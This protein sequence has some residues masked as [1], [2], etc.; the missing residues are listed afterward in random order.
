MQMS[1]LITKLKGLKLELH[2][3][4][5]V[6]LVFNSLP[7]QFDQSNVSY[8][9]LKEKWSL[10][11]LTAQCVQ[12]KEGFKKNKVETAHLASSSCS[13]ETTL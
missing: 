10:N 9:T 5:L 1:N 12:E 8:N 2:D 6:H 13:E 3:D 4:F 7:V 11:E